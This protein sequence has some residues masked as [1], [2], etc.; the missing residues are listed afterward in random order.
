MYVVFFWK[1]HL[2][3]NLIMGQDVTEKIAENVF[4]ET[5]WKEMV[6]AG[7]IAGHSLVYF[8]QI[9]STNSRAMEMGL[10]GAQA[11]TVVFAESQTGGKGR[12][13][14]SWDSPAGSGLY[15][16]IILRPALAIGDLSKITLA[17]GVALCRMVRRL[18]SFSPQIKWPNDLLVANRKCG[19]ILV[20]AD[21]RNQSAP[22]VI[23]GIGLNV[24][25]PSIDF[26]EELRESATSL[27]CHVDIPIRRKEL[28]ETVLVETDAVIGQFEQQ[29]FADILKEW[30]KYDA[31]LG[32]TL[33]WI[34]A[35]R[36]VVKGVS[37]G[38]DNEGK[39][40]IK[41]GDGRVHEVISGDIRLASY[42]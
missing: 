18:Y 9:D 20:E 39:L 28:L 4:D 42:P 34:T 40:H 2:P 5:D 27:Q 22:L 11:G 21:L 12:L 35:D 19:G 16:S 15:F 13:G 14:K 8:Q 6:R 25:T 23:L 7:E 41:S 30:K 29:G 10:A 32:R 33:T 3:Y 36:Q 17:A 38:P 37:L 31:T 24:T 26:P 1:E